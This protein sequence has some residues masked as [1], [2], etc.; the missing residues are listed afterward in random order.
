V[1]SLWLPLL[2]HGGLVAALPLRFE[3]E[4]CFERVVYHPPLLLFLLLP[5]LLTDG[6]ARRSVKVSMASLQ[7][8][9]RRCCG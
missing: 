3:Q 4:L 6:S 2:L 1:K 5:P 8:L 7:P 9:Q